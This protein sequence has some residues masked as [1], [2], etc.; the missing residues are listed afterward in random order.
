MDVT[1]LTLPEIA[2][3][4]RSLRRLYP[5]Y[6]RMSRELNLSAC[7]VMEYPVDRADPELLKEAE[8]WFATADRRS[9]VFQLR[10]AVQAVRTSEETLHA[11][12]ARHLNKP[13]KLPR[14]TDK[15]HFLL[16]Q[17]FACTTPM[18][19]DWDVD[20]QVVSAVMQNLLG[21]VTGTRPDWL[22]PLNETL[23]DL[24]MCGSLRDL[25]EMRILERGRELKRSAGDRFYESAALVEFTRYNFLARRGFIRLLRSDLQAAE[26]GLAAL[27]V[28]GVMHVDASAMSRSKSEPIA[29]LTEIC[30]RWRAPL[31]GEY[32]D[33]FDEVIVLRDVVEQAAWSEPPRAQSLRANK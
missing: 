24:F 33:G 26:S 3:R 25:R 8:A 4:W 23:S 21:N 22:T 12:C 31:R 17:Y 13:V 32:Y 2:A 28:N 20:F 16:T 30:R 15:L 6:A 5:V 14:D 18:L 11:L 10:Q 7:E 9:Q 19:T 1:A 27:Q 29:A